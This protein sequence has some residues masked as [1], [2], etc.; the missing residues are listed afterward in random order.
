MVASKDSGLRPPSESEM[1]SSSGSAEL[2]LRA[3][4]HTRAHTSIRQQCTRTS[5]AQRRVVRR[6][7]EKGLRSA[8]AHR[9]PLSPLT[10]RIRAQN[11]FNHHAQE[12]EKVRVRCPREGT[13][14]PLARAEPAQLGG[15]T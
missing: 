14:I 5:Q 7:G 9:A 12:R 6:E 11:A 3:P 13:G 4:Q 10:R 1:A 2:L 8:T 15:P